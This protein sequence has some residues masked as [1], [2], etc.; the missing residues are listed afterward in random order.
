MNYAK[1]LDQG[2]RRRSLASLDSVL[3]RHEFLI[4][5][6]FFIAFMALTLPGISWGAPAVWHPDEVVIRSLKALQGDWAYYE[7]NYN[8]PF[9]PQNLMYLVGRLVLTLG[10][11]MAGAL[12]AARVISAVL[13]G[14]SIV[15][16]YHITR[17]LGASI[18]IAA[19][20]S[21]LL[22]VASEMVHNGH[23][24]H[25]DAYVTFFSTL[26]I[27]CLVQYYSLDRRGWLY[28]A[29]FAAG[30]AFSS[31]YTSLLLAMAPVLVYLFKQASGFL[32][33]RLSFLEPLFIGA[34]LWVLG[35]GA[36]TPKFLTWNSWF[37]KRL[38]PA[39]FYNVTFGEQPGRLRG[40]L[41]QFPALAETLGIALLAI[42]MAA[43]VW[44]VYIVFFAR[45]RPAGIRASLSILLLCLVLLDLPLAVSYN[46]AVRYLLPLLPIMAVLSGLFFGDLYSWVVFRSGSVAGR[47]LAAALA[48]MIVVSLAR[49]FTVM[50]F[51]LNDSRFAAGHFLESLPDGSSL[52]ETFYSPS[53]PSHKFEREH[54]YP[55]YFLRSP[56]EALPVSKKYDFNAGEAGLLE[57][58]T[59]YLI[60]D[61][62]TAAKF[63][64]PYTCQ[65]M[66]LEC[67]FFKQLA[68]GGSVHYRLLAS[69]SYS[70]P[71]F[72]PRVKVDFVNP[73]IRIFERVK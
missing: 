62:F 30:L 43:L 51:F 55:L 45:H 36:G 23:F 42:Y 1:P 59:D 69:F 70:P 25:T 63:N 11:T 47:L 46:L 28:A 22:L 61:S 39:L 18:Y 38:I 6:F 7:A 4:P 19:L 67:D 53:V 50:L 73:E 32:K 2:I 8:H 40:A 35:F 24:A 16:V 17:R 13:L 72:L 27:F 20:S 29:F 41:S 57:R 60:V 49:S 14:L 48:L 34:V 65:L 71:W 33:H 52:E 66:Q 37:L 54:N 12:D 31:K 9:L 21:L 10:G 64:N 68:A 44:A 5:L 56:G 15:L 58:G 3:S 26:T